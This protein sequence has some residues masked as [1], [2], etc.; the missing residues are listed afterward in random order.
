MALNHQLKIQLHNLIGRTVNHRG[1]T[2]TVVEVLESEPA[3]VL[4]AQGSR[5]SLQDN[6]YGNPGRR[7]PEVFTIPLFDEEDRSEFHP[8]LLQ[9][10]LMPC[11]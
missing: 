5:T 3:L 7:V 8:D 9:L 4:E 10:G 11:E 1:V 6:Q 2:C